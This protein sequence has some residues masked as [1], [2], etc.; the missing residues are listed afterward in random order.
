MQKGITL[1]DER[2]DA[3]E[4]KLG[5]PEQCDREKNIIITRLEGGKINQESIRKKL[6]VNLG[7]SISAADINDVYKLMSNQAK[8]PTRVRVGLMK[9]KKDVMKE[10]N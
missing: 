9:D 1:R 4:K 5:E 8:T 7:M 6:N 2:M 10:R 3:M